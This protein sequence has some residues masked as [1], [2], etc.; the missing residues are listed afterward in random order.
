MEKFEVACEKCG[1]KIIIEPCCG[2]TEHSVRP[3]CK[4]CGGEDYY[5]PCGRLNNINDSKKK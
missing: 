5:R 4:K 2:A 3:I 1:A